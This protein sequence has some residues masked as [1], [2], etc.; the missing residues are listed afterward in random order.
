VQ[1]IATVPEII[2]EG[3]LGLWLTFRGFKG[4]APILAPDS[5]EPAITPAYAA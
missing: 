2:W 3:F 1:G 4:S 5:E